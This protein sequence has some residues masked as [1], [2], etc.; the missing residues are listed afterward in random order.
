LNL[1]ILASRQN[2]KNL[3]INFGAIHVRINYANFQASSFTGVGGG[4]GDRPTHTGRQAFL[5]R[6]VFKISKL[7]PRFAQDELIIPYC[8]LKNLE[9][10]KIFLKSGKSLVFFFDLKK[11][12]KCVEDKKTKL[13]KCVLHNLW[14]ISF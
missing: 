1:N 7:L 11:S 12:M 3:I 6:S 10:Q 14:G 4:G 5:N 9:K 13:Q 2:I 8:S